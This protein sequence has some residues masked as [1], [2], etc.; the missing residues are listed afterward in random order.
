M[1]ANGSKGAERLNK[2]AER[3]ELNHEDAGVPGLGHQASRYRCRSGT[4]RHAAWQAG[5][6]TGDFALHPLGAFTLQR[7]GNDP[8]ST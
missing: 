2:I 5:G 8:N 4:R 1:V 3:R 6:T 7:R